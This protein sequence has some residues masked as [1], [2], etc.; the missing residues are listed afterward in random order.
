MNPPTIIGVASKSAVKIQSVQTAVAFLYP[1]SSSTTTII[2]FNAK[3]SIAEQPVGTEWGKQGALNRLSD[4]QKQQSNTPQQNT[5]NN[6]QL[7]FSIENFIDKEIND[8]QK[9]FDQAAI[10]IQSPYTTRIIFSEKVYFPHKFVIQAQQSTSTTNNNTNDD[11]ASGFAITCGRFIAKELSVSHDDWHK[12]FPPY[13]SRIDLLQETLVRGI[14]ELILNE[15]GLIQF[16]TWLTTIPIWRGFVIDWLYTRIKML[17]L[18]SA[19]FKNKKLE[20]IIIDEENNG[21][22]NIKTI[23]GGILSDRFQLPLIFLRQGLL[24]LTQEKIVKR[25]GIIVVIGYCIGNNNT[26][27]QSQLLETLKVTGGDGGGEQSTSVIVLFCG[28]CQI[29][30]DHPQQGDKQNLNGGL[31]IAQSQSQLQTYV[32]LAPLN[33]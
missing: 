22:N 33:I 21:G 19:T 13:R 12:S 17:L 1:N 31:I 2:G 3:S 15:N 27:Y 28:V 10:I 29:R 6:I 24:G 9:W 14:L 32:S 4:A 11:D 26:A 25:N 7:W 8:E 20:A 5:T 16:G 18:D 23:L 30:S